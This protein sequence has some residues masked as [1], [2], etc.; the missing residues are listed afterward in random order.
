MVPSN[1]ALSASR[2]G[3]STVLFFCWLSEVGQRFCRHWD[4]IQGSAPQGWE[5]GDPGRMEPS[6]P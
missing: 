4:R 6:V 2:N 1:L 3:A 5:Q